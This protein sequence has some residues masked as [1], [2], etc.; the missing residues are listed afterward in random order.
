MIVAR[1]FGDNSIS[2]ID[3]IKYRDFVRILQNRFQLLIIRKRASKCAPY[4][5]EARINPGLLAGATRGVQF[6]VRRR[7]VL[8][9]KL[10]TLGCLA[11]H[12]SAQGNNFKEVTIGTRSMDSTEARTMTGLPRRP[13]VPERSIQCE[14]DR[15]EAL[16]TNQSRTVVDL[17]QP[18]PEPPE[19]IRAEFKEA[20]DNFSLGIIKTELVSGKYVYANPAFCR[21]VGYARDEL[22]NGD[23]TVAK[24]IHPE[25]AALCV[26]ELQRLVRGEIGTFTVVNRYIRKD[27]SMVSASETISLLERDG[28]APNT[29]AMGVTTPLPDPRSNTGTLVALPNMWFWSRD[30]RTDTGVFSENLKDMF[31]LSPSASLPSFDAIL[32]VI[33]PEDRTRVREDRTRALNGVFQSGEARFFLASGEMRWSA[34]SINPSFDESGAVVSIMCTGMDFT[35]S[36]RPR[37]ASPSAST[38]RLVKRYIDLHWDQPINVAALAD[39]AN[40]NS[41]TLFKHCRT[42]GGFTPSAYLKQV[43]LNHARAMLKAADPTVTVLGVSLKCCFQNAGHFARDYRL[44]FGER[45]SDTLQRSREIHRMT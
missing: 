3:R 6:E 42:G 21:M 25:D 20:A 38:V 4:S 40:V 12:Q 13:L 2:A 7:E 18:D 30:L 26:R 9:S 34:Y 28:P 45:P 16:P 39:A 31:G 32:A 10:S 5:Y 41:R 22:I 33:H 35:D 1:R 19:F 37:L 27:G 29:A 36:T 15:P 44:A 14:R 17:V 11:A 43:R 24:M 23:L 8:Q